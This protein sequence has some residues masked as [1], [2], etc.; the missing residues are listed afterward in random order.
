MVSSIWLDKNTPTIIHPWKFHSSKLCKISS[1][2][3][4]EVNSSMFGAAI[5]INKNNV[6]LEIKNQKSGLKVK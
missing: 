5:N 3:S 1:N 4:S 2:L 6:T